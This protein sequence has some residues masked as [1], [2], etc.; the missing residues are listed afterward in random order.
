MKF[1]KVFEEATAACDVKGVP[2]K[3]GGKKKGKK[4]DEEDGI[5]RRKMYAAEKM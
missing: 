1:Q 2:K 3:V 5:V 4:K